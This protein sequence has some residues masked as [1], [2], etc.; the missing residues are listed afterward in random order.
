MSAKS[1][2]TSCSCSCSISS[3]SCS[4]LCSLLAADNFLCLQQRKEIF[5]RLPARNFSLATAMKIDIYTLQCWA[6]GNTCCLEKKNQEK[7]SLYP[8][9][10]LCSLWPAQH[11]SLLSPICLSNIFIKGS[12]F[13]ISSAFTLPKHRLIADTSI[14]VTFAVCCGGVG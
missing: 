5:C 11:V 10:V 14:W 3:T 4:C 7:N 6:T 8:L 1:G 12:A 13:S 9:T 2:D